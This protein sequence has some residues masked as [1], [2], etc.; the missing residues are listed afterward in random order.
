M[1]WGGIQVVVDFFDIFSVISLVAGDSEQPLLQDGV[2]LVP[3][4]K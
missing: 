1:S 3:E 4:S 2:L